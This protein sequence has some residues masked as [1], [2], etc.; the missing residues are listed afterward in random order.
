M[1]S[2]NTNMSMLGAQT[3]FTRLERDGQ[4]RQER[5]SSGQRINS[6]KDDS[7][8]LSMSEGM[9]AEAGSLA[10]GNRNTEKALDLLRTAE[11]A[12][13]DISSIL[14]RM[15]ELAT[16]AATDT[17]NDANREGLD[18]EFVQ[19]TH[20]IDHIAR[21]TAYNDQV[22]L[23]G[24]GNH[25][26]PAASTVLTSSPTTGV[27]RLTL[28]GANTGTY[29]FIDA[30]G[31]GEITLGN[32][33]ATQTVSIDILLSG[34]QLATG[35]TAVVNFDRLGV[36]LELAG[37][38]ALNAPGAYADGALD[39]HTL[40]V[41]KGVGGTFQ[42][43]SDAVPAD[44]L[45]YDLADMTSSGSVVG[46]TSISIGT[47]QASRA[48]LAKIDA[49]IGRVTSERGAVGAVMNR[50]GHTLEF[51]ASALENVKSSESS[52]RDAD[53]ALEST[54]LTRNQIMRQANQSVMIQSRFRVEVLMGLLQ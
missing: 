16:Q 11:G 7:G 15:R 42:I 17:L 50:L 32:G 30:P 13:G 26:D 6:S 14:I 41:E 5:L 3:D 51:S 47:R 48:A 2:I 45:E 19:L 43:G 33:I 39:G 36:R 40:V 9:R 12:M 1:L 27:Q 21:Q 44:R 34:N 46:L 53:F 23:S 54:A 20:E 24:F 49:A 18:A 4:Q 52:I 25:A 38:Q 37:P 28:S 22:L 8:R 29:S 35:T 31:D 10:E